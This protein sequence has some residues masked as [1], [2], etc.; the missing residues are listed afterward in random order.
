MVLCEIIDKLGFIKMKNFC[1]EKDNVKRMR[2]EATER[3][4]VFAKDI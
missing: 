4:K 2:R 1:S 3:E